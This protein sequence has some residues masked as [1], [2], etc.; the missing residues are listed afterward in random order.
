MR[1]L[2]QQKK[3]FEIDPEKAWNY[4]YNAIDTNK[5]SYFGGDYL[6]KYSRT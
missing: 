5:T 6:P 1:K 4:I 2:R 3:V